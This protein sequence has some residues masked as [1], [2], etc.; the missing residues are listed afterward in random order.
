M[1]SDIQVHHYCIVFFNLKKQ[2]NTFFVF[3]FYSEC[4]EVNSLLDIIHIRKTVEEGVKRL[5]EES[6]MATGDKEKELIEILN[7][8][9]K[10]TNKKIVIFLLNGAFVLFICNNL[11][12][13]N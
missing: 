11:F 7:G 13:L 3:Q 1:S 10:Q 8:N 2:G 4:L 9:V 12:F 6:K 5:K